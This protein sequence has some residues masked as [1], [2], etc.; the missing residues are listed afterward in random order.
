[1]RLDFGLIAGL[2]LSAIDKQALVDRR[3][4]SSAHRLSAASL[5]DPVGRDR[6]D[7]AEGHWRA[8]ASTV[9]CRRQA[10]DVITVLLLTKKEQVQQPAT[11]LEGGGPLLSTG[12]FIL[13][14]SGCA[15]EG[16]SLE[17][18]AASEETRANPL[19]QEEW[20]DILASIALYGPARVV[21]PPHLATAV[22]IEPLLERE[23]VEILTVDL[24]TSLRT[25]IAATYEQA[26]A[27][28][29][30]LEWMPATTPLQSLDAPTP[31]AH[32]RFEAEVLI[33]EAN[34]YIERL[35]VQ[36]NSLLNWLYA[37]FGYYLSVNEEEIYRTIVDINRERYQHI[38][39]S[40]TEDLDSRAE[41]LMRSMGL[42]I[43]GPAEIEAMGLRQPGIGYSPSC[44]QDFE[45]FDRSLTSHA[46]GFDDFA[47]LG[48]WISTFEPEEFMAVHAFWRSFYELVNMMRVASLTANPLFLPSRLAM[49][50]ASPQE[51]GTSESTATS[52]QVYRHFL[53]ESGRLPNPTNLRELERL[54]QDPNVGAL[55]E[56]LAQWTVV[57]QGDENPEASVLAAINRDIDLAARQLRRGELLGR[58][59]RLTAFLAMPV[60]AYDILRGSPWGLA[61]VPVGAAIEAAEATVTKGA[62]WACIGRP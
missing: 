4:L 45:A 32:E 54:R 16:L 57:A 56:M 42:Y 15:A 27:R 14:L 40:K 24:T 11:L 48:L 53:S 31:K 6:A 43:R 29:R 8:P 36:I 60:S 22:R 55:R 38:A 13:L 52:L 30:K 61:L 33:E 20:Q 28:C 19:F 58:V 50:A 25:Q 9:T 44:L 39:T 17:V 51:T 18:D 5:D 23:I 1:M 35:R 3:S 34:F 26:F 59:G 46:E 7:Q 37:I 12:Q 21:L 49:A 47:K 62:S 10:E 2:P 41:N